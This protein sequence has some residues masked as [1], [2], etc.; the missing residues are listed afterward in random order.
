MKIKSFLISFFILIL[1][2]YPADLGES[3][4]DYGF[5]RVRLTQACKSRVIDFVKSK[6]YDSIDIII[7]FGDSINAPNLEWLTEHE[8]FFLEGIKEN[9]E[10]LE[11]EST[12][13]HYFNLYDTI[14]VNGGYYRDYS[15]SPEM[16][17]AYRLHD[18]PSSRNPPP[19]P[20]NENLHL[21]LFLSFKE[22]LT[23]YEKSMPEKV[24]IWEFL[25][26][27]FPEKSSRR[28]EKDDRA[29]EYL[30]KYPDSPLRDLVLYNFYFNYK[31]NKTGAVIGIGGGFA[32]FDDD[33]NK[34]F[35]DRGLV[36]IYL[37]LYFKGLA[38]KFSFMAIPNKLTDSLISGKDTLKTGT[39]VNNI[40]W[41]IESGYLFDFS[42]RLHLTPYAG[43]GIM[44]HSVSDADAKK[45]DVDPDF[46]TTVGIQG[47][48]AL[49]INFAPVKRGD[50]Y[51]SVNTFSL[52]GAR[53]DFG[54]LYNDLT[55]IKEGLGNTGFYINIG[56]SVLG[57]GP[58]RIYEVNEE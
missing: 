55:K 23:H 12:Y 25:R 14:P 10:L 19:V 41:R 34:L 46:P 54:I 3:L 56:I 35:K 18:R 22:K 29:K 58:E 36:T 33:I 32:G 20:K 9:I 15:Y 31:S 8:R 16:Y 45:L 52:L 1:K 7:D 53:V 39:P 11:R 48:I 26:M 6:E 17:K 28:P 4:L 40:L 5:D 21:F 49:D 42:D 50:R 44:V 2:A 24:Y 13:V 47:G 57:W 38:G 43:V 37:D 30:I 51:Q 27:L